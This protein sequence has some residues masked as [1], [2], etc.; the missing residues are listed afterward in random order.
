MSDE[1]AKARFG[2]Q[3]LVPKKIWVTRE[4]KKFKTTVWVMPHF[5]KPEK[6]QPAPKPPK[7][8]GGE[9]I[10]SQE[11]KSWFGDWS[12]GEGSKVIKKGGEPAENYNLPTAVYH[13]TAVG[14][15]T[16]FSK[17]FALGGLYGGGFYFTEEKNIAEGYTTKDQDATVE[18]ATGLKDKD[19][20]DV[21]TIPY[22]EVKDFVENTNI[23][24]RITPEKDLQEWERSD[25]HMQKRAELIEAVERVYGKDYK[26][27]P[28]GDR[29]NPNWTKHT[30]SLILRSRDE[31]G[32]VD[33][34]KF[35]ELSQ[36]PDT[37]YLDQH[38]FRA[39]D[40]EN[41][42]IKRG[43]DMY[44]QGGRFKKE[45]FEEV[46]GDKYTPVIP[47]SQV[48][49]VYLNVRNPLDLDGDMMQA[50]PL[51]DEMQHESV[52]KTLEQNEN[53][54]N[55]VREE[56]ETF[57]K[58]HESDKEAE[59]DEYDNRYALDKR[60]SIYAKT[61]K[62]GNAKYTV[63]Y[64]EDGDK[65][66]DYDHYNYKELDE[67]SDSELKKVISQFDNP[68][69]PNFVHFKHL[70]D[71]FYDQDM[72]VDWARKNGYEDSVSTYKRDDG[73]TRTYIGEGAIAGTKENI[74]ALATLLAKSG[75]AGYDQETKTMVKKRM[76]TMEGGKPTI[77]H[78]AFVLS[79]GGGFNGGTRINEWA[80]KNG[81]DG[82][83]HTGGWNFTN[84]ADGDLHKV[85]IAFEP[86]QIK[87]TNATDFD[88]DSNNIYK[89]FDELIRDHN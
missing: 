73:T 66:K 4:G 16:E 55:K 29:G 32:D 14:G 39:V 25:E 63:K 30:V 72:L 80:K 18:M 71:R 38:S 12:K 8:E 17:N 7:K 81:Y 75:I 46:L 43:R 48:Y 69:N 21:S 35:V 58:W 78:L 41:R 59:G 60:D 49:E 85:W 9:G 37:E 15:F 87:S 61:D 26:N 36:D 40:G 74:L 2:T 62:D 42:F 34:K 1:I 82:L 19:G 67:M 50:E 27:N 76:P 51:L 53:Q 77:Q 83:A 24:V 28:D 89:A 44:T 3:G 31:N 22:S 52:E 13:G 11:F 47:D 88:P 23:D 33:V 20:N 79:D 10:H 64:Y 68:D 45:F 54:F 57:K 70:M 6:D 84:V 65:Y 86:N 5:R 56:I